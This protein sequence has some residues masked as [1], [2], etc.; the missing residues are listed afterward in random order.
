MLNKLPNV[1]LLYN[2]KS[3]SMNSFVLIVKLNL[4]YWDHVLQW[5]GL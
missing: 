4:L 3:F 1:L 5:H 2:I